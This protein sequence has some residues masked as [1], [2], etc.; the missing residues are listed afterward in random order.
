MHENKKNLMCELCDFASNSKF[1]R[2]THLLVEHFMEK[3]SNN[4]PKFSPYKCIIG[5]CVFQ[6]NNK[7]DLQQHYIRQHNILEKFMKEELDKKLL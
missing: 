3:L 4:F 6:T 5:N 1:Q 2:E 7:Y